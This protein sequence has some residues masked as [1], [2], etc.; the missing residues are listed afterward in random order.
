M[1]WAQ[2]GFD[3]HSQRRFL[4]AFVQLKQ[5]WMTRPDADPDYFRDSFGRKCSDA[6]DWKKEWAKLNRAEF[7]TQGRLHFFPN[8]GEKTE[9]EMHLIAGRPSNAAKMWIQRHQNFPDR[10]R[11]ID[12][13]EQPA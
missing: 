2:F 6:F 11:R 5:V 8:F 3:A 12:G 9:C 7:F 4:H 10:F 13:N 1:P